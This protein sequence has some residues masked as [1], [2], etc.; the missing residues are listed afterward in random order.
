MKVKTFDSYHWGICASFRV[1]NKHTDC[2][3]H[4]WQ[5]KK[6]LIDTYLRYK[7]FLSDSMDILQ[8]AMWR[9]LE[10]VKECFV[11]QDFPGKTI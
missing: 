3:F 5:K 6:T 9:L 10:N 1:T 2:L 11:Y 4:F 8:I 7:T